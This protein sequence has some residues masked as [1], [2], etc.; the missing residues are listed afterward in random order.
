MTTAPTIGMN[1]PRNTSTPMG[2]A[3]GTPMIAAPPAMPTASMRATSTCTFT[4]FC[5]VLQPALP[6]P[7]TAGRASR[8]KRRTTQRHMPAPSMR[9]KRVEKSTSSTPVST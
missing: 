8:G 4:K 6:A 7:S 5:S 2:I 1:E 3:S 9:M